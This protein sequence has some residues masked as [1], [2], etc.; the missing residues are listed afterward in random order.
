MYRRSYEIFGL[1]SWEVV[2]QHVKI[3]LPIILIGF[4]I[5][6]LVWWF[7]IAQR[8]RAKSNDTK[9]R[10]VDGIGFL[11]IFIMIIGAFFLMPLLTRIESIVGGITSFLFALIL[12]GVIIIGGGAWLIKNI[13]R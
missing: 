9:F 1:K 8:R 12:A 13:R 10:F 7:P 6:G 2:W 4:L 3:A 5:G 11:G